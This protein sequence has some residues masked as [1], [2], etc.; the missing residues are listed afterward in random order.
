[1]ICLPKKDFSWLNVP[2]LMKSL[3]V[4]D[5]YEKFYYNHENWHY[6]IVMTND[7]SHTSN[8]ENPGLM[9]VYNQNNSVWCDGKNI[10]E[11]FLVGVYAFKIDPI[12]NK[13][14]RVL[15]HV[16]PAEFLCK[17]DFKE[18]GSL[19][20]KFEEREHL[21]AGIDFK[22]VCFFIDQKFVS[23]VYDLLKDQVPLQRA[24]ED[25][26]FE[27]LKVEMEFKD[28]MLSLSYM[29][30]KKEPLAVIKMDDKA[31]AGM[32]FEQW[33]EILKGNPD[34]HKIN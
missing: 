18:R 17:I 1:M 21:D 30:D 8:F 15:E 5:N 34:W 3:R 4:F 2:G 14:L 7:K 28:K 31:S 24:D 6:L 22:G 26:I 33:L 13:V 20:F 10:N 12:Q 9:I 32:T 16:N 19:E 11:G 27:A 23:E 25:V 29:L